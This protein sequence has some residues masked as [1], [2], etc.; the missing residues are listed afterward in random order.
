MYPLYFTK[1]ER[2][3]LREKL[4]ENLIPMSEEYMETSIKFMNHVM[5]HGIDI[6][7]KTD[8]KKEE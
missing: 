3:F 2:D 6:H 5:E 4:I 8:R 7:I 1:N